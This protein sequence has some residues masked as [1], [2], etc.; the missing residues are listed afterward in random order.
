[1]KALLVR[2]AFFFALYALAVKVFLYSLA[3]CGGPVLPFWP[4]FWLFNAGTYLL[5]RARR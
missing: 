4:A 3:A 1:M 2:T 5:G